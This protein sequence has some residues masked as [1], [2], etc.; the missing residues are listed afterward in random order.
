MGE[1]AI[2]HVLTV[3]ILFLVLTVLH[4]AVAAAPA[5][6]S[7]LEPLLYRLGVCETGLDWQFRAGSYQGF[8]AWYSSTWD[9]DK[10]AGYPDHAWQATPRQQ[11]LVARRSL[12]RGRYFGCLHGPEH[13]WV[14]GR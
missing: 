8:V 5:R 12:R 7:W 1:G 11:A 14:R 3:T 6:P 2:R 4:E 9:L 13:A 10:P